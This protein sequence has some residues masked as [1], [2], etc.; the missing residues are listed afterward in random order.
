MRSPAASASGEA[1]AARPCCSAPPCSGGVPA[2]SALHWRVADLHVPCCMVSLDFDWISS[3]ILLTLRQLQMARRW[4]HMAEISMTFDDL[5]EGHSFYM[6]D[7]E[8][9]EE[10]S[11]PGAQ[12]RHRLRSRPR[13][14]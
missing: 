10:G 8:E 11:E 5:T 2:T 7:L 9:K 13:P 1:P 3:F 4:K 14:D 6:G 12:H